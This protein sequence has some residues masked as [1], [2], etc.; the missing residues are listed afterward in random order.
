MD[1]DHSRILSDRKTE[2]NSMQYIVVQE[3]NIQQGFNPG[4]VQSSIMKALDVCINLEPTPKPKIKVS[5]NIF[6]N[7][8]SSSNT[9]AIDHQPPSRNLKEKDQDSIANL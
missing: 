2:L 3:S 1:N 6:D 4:E 9:G 7:R 8:R 5:K